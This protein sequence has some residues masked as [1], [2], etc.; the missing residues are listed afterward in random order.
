MFKTFLQ[1]ICLMIAMAGVAFAH[2]GSCEKTE[3]AGCQAKEGAH[4]SKHKPHSSYQAKIGDLVLSH[5]FMRPA[6]KAGTPTSAYIQIKNNG[7]IDD[8]L[9]RVTT[10]IAEKA[11]IHSS[12][13]DNNGIV[14]MRKIEKIIIPA[15]ETV[16]LKPRHDHIMVMGLKEP[17]PRGAHIPLM[18]D[19]AQ[20]GSKMV[21]FPVRHGMKHRHDHHH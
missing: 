8:A 1:F 9:V 14:R 18:L 17:I 5:A 21:S 3:C 12:E 4:C 6:A 20:A 10:D 13:V 11:E 7:T 15:G 2:C 16:M 19:F